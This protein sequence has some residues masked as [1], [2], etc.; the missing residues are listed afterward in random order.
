M[1]PTMLDM[2]H[3]TSLR[4]SPLPPGAKCTRCKA[5]AEIRMLSHNANFC[6]DCFRIYFRTAVLRAM[7]WFDLPASTPL[8]VAVSGGKDSL[9]V[10]DVLHEAG[11]ATKGLHV[12]LGIDEF[13]AASSESVRRFAESRGLSW[14]EYPM[15]EMFGYTIP[16]IRS[17]TRRAICSVCGLLKRQLLNRLCIREGYSALVVGHNLDDEAGRLLGNILRHRRQYIEKQ[18]PFLPS[19]DPRLPA[20]LKPLYRLESHEIRTYCRLRDIHPLA[21]KCPMSRGATSHVVKEALDFLEAKMPGTK[22]DFL[23]TFLADRKTPAGAQYF[24][25]CARCGQPA[26][27]DQCSLCNLA[28]LLETGRKKEEESPGQ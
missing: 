16:A 22:R 12:S 10:W 21:A 5:R 28:E 7:K 25:T 6:P 13:S 26:Y 2:S 23:F 19:P 4:E 18:S 8:M 27:A 17:K 15:E 1:T 3:E 14:V 11:Y 9:A 24:G 20:K